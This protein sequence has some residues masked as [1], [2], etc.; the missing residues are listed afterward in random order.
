VLFPVLASCGAR[1]RER[2]PAF[3]GQRVI[4]VLESV[5][6]GRVRHC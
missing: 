3:L 5:L 6:G 2:G 4:D 1:I